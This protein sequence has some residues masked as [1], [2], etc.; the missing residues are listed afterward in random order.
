VSK[1]PKFNSTSCGACK[2]P[3]GIHNP[4]CWSYGL[5]E[6]KCRKHCQKFVRKNEKSNKE[7]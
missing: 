1:Q 5:I 7:N 3:K 2:H 6:P 4:Q